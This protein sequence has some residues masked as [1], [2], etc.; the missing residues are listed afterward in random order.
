MILVD[1]DFRWERFCQA[2]DDAA[3]MTGKPAM[4][5]YMRAWKYK[6]PQLDTR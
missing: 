2:A 5:V 1:D 3:V 4:N 6:E